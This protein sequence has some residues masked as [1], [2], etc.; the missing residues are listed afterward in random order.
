MGREKKYH[1]NLSDEEIKKL[2]KVMNN[3]KTCRTIIRRCAI[4]IELNENAET[5]KGLTQRQLAKS[6]GVSTNTTSNVIRDYATKGI[7]A[8]IKINR[9]PN[10]NAKLKADGRVEAELIRM[11][12]GS[13]P[14]GRARWTLRLLEKQVVIELEDSISRETIRRV[15]KKTNLSLI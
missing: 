10:S 7:S 11:A 6:F 9:N 8:I 13:A 5:Y 14:E 3:K 4:L 2:R 1:I 12:C 15:L